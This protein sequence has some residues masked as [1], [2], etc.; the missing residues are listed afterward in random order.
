MLGFPSH[1]L[2]IIKKFVGLHQLEDEKGWL[3][4]GAGSVISEARLIYG[5]TSSKPA[6]ESKEGAGSLTWLWKQ[7]VA[8]DARERKSFA[9]G[10]GTRT[11]RHEGP[12]L[13]PVFSPLA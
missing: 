9:A 2:D 3:V 7:W 5:F 8:W 1:Y 10:G 4:G 13:T 11:Q 12:V 6:V